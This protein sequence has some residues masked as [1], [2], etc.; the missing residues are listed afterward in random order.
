MTDPKQ[1][2]NPKTQT[3]AEKRK[4]PKQEVRKDDPSPDELIEGEGTP[5]LTITGGGGHA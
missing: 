3:E 4:A 5:G 1:K 2:S